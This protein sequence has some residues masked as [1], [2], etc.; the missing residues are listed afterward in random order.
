MALSINPATKV[1]TI[2]QAD[3][4]LVTGTLYELDTN[5][6]RKDV[7]G[8][9]DDE[10]FVWM[11]DAFLHNTEVTVAGTTFARTLEFINGYSVEFENFSYSVRLVGS[12]NNIFDV[13]N[14]IL[15][16]NLVQVIPTNS[17]GLIT[18]VSGSGVTSQDKT[19]IIDGVWD[20]VLSEHVT[21]GTSGE[22]LGNVASTVWDATLADHTT[23]D[24]TG[25]ALDNMAGGSSPST[26]ADAVWSAT[27]VEWSGITAANLVARTDTVT[28]ENKVL[29]Q[30]IKVIANNT[31]AVSV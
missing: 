28:S 11:P 3:L 26:I 22:A 23:V 20:E 21:V 30:E 31:L 18:V 13:E 10:D 14:G 19:D 27:R 24:T 9:L 25:Y 17:A 16:Q 29:N 5:Q 15:V 12:N 8:L 2:P 7:M 6:F 1:I 4:T